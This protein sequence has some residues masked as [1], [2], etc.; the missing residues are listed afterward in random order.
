M[1]AE[2]PDSESS[3]KHSIPGSES[4]GSKSSK[5]DE[6]KVPWYESSLERK[7]PGTKVP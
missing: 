2:V 4:S 1:E 6:T 5:F 3:G 7:F